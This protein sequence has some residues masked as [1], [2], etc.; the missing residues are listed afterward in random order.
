MDEE[1]KELKL[2]LDKIKE[3]VK[4]YFG[5][6]RSESRLVTPAGVAILK[7]TN[8][9]SV[10]PE[11]VPE[12]KKIY[13]DDFGVFVEEKVR[14]SPTAALRKLLANGD[15]KYADTIRQ[16]VE[17]TTAYSVQFEKAVVKIR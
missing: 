6:N 5:E 15:Y 16:A 11:Y 13:K 3:E 4:E 7:V 12:L 2:D 1:I 14:Y 17:I 8:S 10:L 9:Y